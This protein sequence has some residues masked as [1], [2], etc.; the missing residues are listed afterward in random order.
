M[1]KNYRLQKGDRR[2]QTDAS[3][4]AGATKNTHALIT[5]T[6]MTVIVTKAE[7]TK[8]QCRQQLAVL[9]PFRS[10]SFLFRWSPLENL[11]ASDETKKIVAIVT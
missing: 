2:Q 6:T 5:V 11:E 3:Y 4:N 7:M 1:Q 9:V 10:L 8:K